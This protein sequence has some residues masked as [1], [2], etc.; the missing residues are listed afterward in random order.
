[1]INEKKAYELIQSK[2][3][4]NDII[5]LNIDFANHLIKNGYKVKSKSW[6]ILEAIRSNYAESERA[7]KNRLKVVEKNI[8]ETKRQQDIKVTEDKRIK[9]EEKTNLY[10]KF[11][12]FIFFNKL[13]NKFITIFM[14]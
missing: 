1:M 7:W 3:I 6:F 13:K 5:S 11:H 14:F 9:K 12:K 10:N 4:S 8:E 2:D